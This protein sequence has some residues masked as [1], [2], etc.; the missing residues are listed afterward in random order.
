MDIRVS[1][2]DA[3][4]SGVHIACL[5]DGSLEFRHEDGSVVSASDRLQLIARSRSAIE[6]VLHNAL[7]ANQS[8][9]RLDA[10]VPEP[11]FKRLPAKQNSARSAPR[12]VEPMPPDLPQ[13]SLAQ[14]LVPPL[15]SAIKNR[16]ASEHRQRIKEY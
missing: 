13:R 15:W 6:E 16:A 4:Q 14:W 2:G 10:H 3:A 1:G 8:L 5:V 12:P 7:A 9:V 11:A